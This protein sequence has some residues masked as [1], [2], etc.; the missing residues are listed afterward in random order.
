MTAA[1]P[2]IWHVSVRG[3]DSTD[4]VADRASA[5]GWE[6]IRTECV[7]LASGSGRVIDIVQRGDAVRL[8]EDM[9]RRPV[10]VVYNGK[11][12]V[13]LDPRPPLRDD[14]TVSLLQFCRYKSFAVSVRSNAA[15][16][17][18]SVFD[19]WVKG[20]E[21]DGSNDPRVLPFHLFAAKGS[22]ELDVA[23]ERGRFRRSHQHRRALVDQLKRRWASAPPGAR[24]GRDPQIVRGLRLGAGFHWDVTTSGRPVLTTSNTTWRVGLGGYINIYPD[25][26]VRVGK[27]CGQTW[28]AGQ[29]ATADED[30]RKRSLPR[31]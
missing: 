15:A 7:R 1:A 9:H 23:A 18:D 22:Y 2:R 4:D 31:K 25:G 11:P 13:R 28:S 27:Q 29:S 20:V 26:H 21:C 3:I 30:D 19:D 10:A 24:H 16:T 14:R 17:W 12:R 5:R 6:T 8:Y